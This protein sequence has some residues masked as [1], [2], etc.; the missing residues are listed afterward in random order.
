MM[1]RGD[2]DDFDADSTAMLLKQ[3]NIAAIFLPGGKVMQPGNRLVQRNLA[4]TLKLI[5]DGGPDAF[6]KGPI[7]D[8]VV[9][10][11][12]AHGGILTKADYLPV[13]RLHARLSAST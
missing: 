12:Q 3:P 9:A 8:A 1:V 6:Y 10:A 5:R 7:A 2:V 4:A 11:S 13:P